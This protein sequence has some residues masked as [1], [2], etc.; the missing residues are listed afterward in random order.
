M[1]PKTIRTHI[2]IL[3]N[4]KHHKDLKNPFF[5]ISNDIEKRCIQKLQV[6]KNYIFSLVQ[7]VLDNQ[8][9]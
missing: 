6:Q 7:R 3:F 1:N 2:S 8:P 5:S 9:F 4:H